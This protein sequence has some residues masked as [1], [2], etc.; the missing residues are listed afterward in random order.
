MRAGS[1]PSLGME[2]AFMFLSLSVALWWVPGTLWVMR[3]S[4]PLGECQPNKRIYAVYG[5]G[6]IRQLSLRVYHDQ[7]EAD[8]CVC[9]GTVFLGIKGCLYGIISREYWD[10]GDSIIERHW[11]WTQRGNVEGWG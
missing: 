2:E 9:G 5:E 7:V 11:V 4:R 6:C 8:R 3:G 1:F 10:G